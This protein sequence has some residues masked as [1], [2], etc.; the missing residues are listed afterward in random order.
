M[1]DLERKSFMCRRRGS[2]SPAIR[3]TPAS[4]FH[5]LLISHSLSS[6][7]LP[8]GQRQGI[9]GGLGSVNGG[10]SSAQAPKDVLKNERIE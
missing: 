2:H 5:T 3:K 4:V 6:Q 1:E 7:P 10:L 8:R 9:P